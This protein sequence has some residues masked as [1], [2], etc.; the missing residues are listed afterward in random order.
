[1]SCRDARWYLRNRGRRVPNASCYILKELFYELFSA[2]TH[3]DIY[4]TEDEGFLPDAKVAIV[5]RSCFMSC[6]LQGHTL[7]STKQRTEGSWC[8]LLYTVLKEL[9]YE[10][11][12]AGTHVDIYETEDE[13][14]LMPVAIL[15]RSYFMSCILQGRTLISTK[16]RTKGS[17]CQLLYCEGVILWVVSSRDARWYLRNRERRVP[18]VKVAGTHADIYETENEG[19]LM[20]VVI[21]WRSCFMSCVLQAH[22]LMSKLLYIEVV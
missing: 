10:L 22:T 16:Q 4:E 12:P 7:I 19:F 13:G 21:L 1:M 8:Q 5:W 3:A 11:S 9:F 20:P 2:G 14:F 18:D 17:W 15:W 6:F